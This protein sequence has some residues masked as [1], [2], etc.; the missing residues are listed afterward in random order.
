MIFIITLLFIIIIIIILTNQT[1][2]EPFYM[3]NY[4]PYNYDCTS[5]NLDTCMNYENCGIATVNG[6]KRCVPGDV[7]GPLYIENAD[8]WTYKNYY[9]KHIFNES[10]Q[11]RD[12]NTWAAFYPIYDVR[13][14]SPTTNAALV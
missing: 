6:S 5:L 13:Y 10:D 7:F 1:A 2:I 14:P 8:Y 12:Y 9:D 11:P 4:G 3:L